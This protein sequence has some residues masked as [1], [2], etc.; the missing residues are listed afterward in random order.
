MQANHVADKEKVVKK[1]VATLNQ[2]ADNKIEK[3]ENIESKL[4][5]ATVEAET[6]LKTKF[7]E[8][9]TEDYSAK[10]DEELNTIAEQKF[11]VNLDETKTK[12][13][14]SNYN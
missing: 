10:T 7:S 2:T 3:A 1:T 4:V 8:K 14:A 13:E 12:I 11:G 9:F 5:K 6:A